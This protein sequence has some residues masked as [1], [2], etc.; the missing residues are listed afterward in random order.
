MMAMFRCIAK[1]DAAAVR[2]ARHFLKAGHPVEAWQMFGHMVKRDTLK[3]TY[4]DALGL[5]HHIILQAGHIAIEDGY[6]PWPAILDWCL[7]GMSTCREPL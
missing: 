3:S 1:A 5:D 6:G 7:N 4:T 2:A